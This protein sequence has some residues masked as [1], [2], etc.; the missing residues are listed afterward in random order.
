MD[1]PQAT[2]LSMGM[3]MARVPA[4]AG[5]ITKI[6][7]ASAPTASPSRVTTRLVVPRGTSR[8]FRSGH[9]RVMSRTI[10]GS[11]T[12]RRAVAIRALS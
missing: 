11:D 1:L 8:R 12:V 9:S 3:I 10:C 2:S 5:T 7:S 4:I 6:I